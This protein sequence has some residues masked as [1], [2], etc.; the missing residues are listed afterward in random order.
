MR[1]LWERAGLN[2]PISDVMVNWMRY[3]LVKDKGQWD[4][5][6]L[7]RGL[8]ELFSIHVFLRM[9]GGDPK[10]CPLAR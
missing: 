5:L 8:L 2:T 6:S 1:V 3:F 10:A 7:E 4:Y 9:R